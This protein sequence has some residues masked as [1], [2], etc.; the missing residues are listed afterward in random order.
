MKKIILAA[1][2][3][4]GILS[5]QAQ[6]AYYTPKFDHNWSIGLDGGVTTPLSVHHKFFGD[7]RG[8]VGIHLQK[9][10]SPV[11]ALGVEGEFGINTSSWFREKQPV[12]FDNS[13][14]GIYGSANLFNLFGG[15]KHR[16]FDIELTAGAG[17]GRDDT[18]SG[19][20]DEGDRAFS[21]FMTKAGVNL[22]FNI[23]R[24]ITISLKPFVAWNMTGSI[25]GMPLN[26]GQTTA[27]YSR[28]NATFNCL[29]GLTYNF[30]PGFVTAD[31]NN[32]AEID[33]LN[34]NINDLRGQ[35]AATKESTATTQA[36]IASLT[37]DLEACREVKPQI[38]ENKETESCILYKFASAKITSDQQPYVETI[39]RYLKQNPQSSVIIK[40]YASPEGPDEY[41]L[42]LS[43]SRADS[44][45]NMLIKKYGIEANRIEAKGEGVGNV[46][47]KTSW[48]RVS[49]CTVDR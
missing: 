41:N 28:N 47:D 37:A 32:Q 39:A 21:Y 16:V 9:Q 1:L 29:V 26:V 12:M 4:A 48:N 19:D 6:K 30:G 46:F 40:G 34:N 24:H 15:Y 33:N 22:N 38:I 45:K 18:Y 5:S 10:I 31:I 11:F 42:N 27:A 44:V 43:Q 20:N 25:Y 23:N 17:W 49:I 2:F 3:A 8:M 14:V 7:M 13:Y 35:I 36:R